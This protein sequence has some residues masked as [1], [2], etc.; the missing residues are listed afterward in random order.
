MNKIILILVVNISVY[1]LES[2][3][4]LVAYIAHLNYH[5][6]LDI[7]TYVY[8]NMDY[9]N[10]NNFIHQILTFWWAEHLCHVNILKLVSFTQCLQHKNVRKKL[11]TYCKYHVHMSKI[12]MQFL[13]MIQ[14]DNFSLIKKWGNCKFTTPSC[15]KR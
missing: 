13:V 6:T 15:R 9:Q 3:T 2:N 5:E 14:S 12:K 10:Q 1:V 7:I 11:A 4:A 8:T